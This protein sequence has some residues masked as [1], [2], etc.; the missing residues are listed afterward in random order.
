[1]SCREFHELSGVYCHECR[2]RQERADIEHLLGGHQGT[3]NRQAL[4]PEKLPLYYE[5]AKETYGRTQ[6]ALLVTFKDDGQQEVA[7]C[8][9]SADHDFQGGP[10]QDTVC[11]AVG[12][13]QTIVPLEPEVMDDDREGCNQETLPEI[14][15]I[16]TEKEKIHGIGIFWEPSRICDDEIR[17]AWWQVTIKVQFM[18]RS[19]MT[20]FRCSR[21]KPIEFNKS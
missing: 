7:P 2:L 12:S 16:R 3:E 13:N 18:K 1:M 4:K 8:E 21:K 14:S 15:L 5:K 17:E 19:I 10:Y 20:R 11:F 6:T 9:I